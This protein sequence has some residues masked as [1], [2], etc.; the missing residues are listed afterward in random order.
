M[1]FGSSSKG[2]YLFNKSLIIGNPKANV[3]PLPFLYIKELNKYI[4]K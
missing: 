3:F 2:K 4:N 1:I